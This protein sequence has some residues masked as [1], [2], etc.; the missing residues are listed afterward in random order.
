MVVAATDHKR[1]TP[2]HRGGKQLPGQSRGG[3]CLSILTI[4]DPHR[5]V[6]GGQGHQQAR[7]AHDRGVKRTRTGVHLP[8]GRERPHQR[9]VGEVQ[10][11][12]A[13]VV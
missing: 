12:Q 6:R 10:A 5:A 8:R 2:H 4:Q 1:A 9:A 13:A 3:H 11:V 7:P